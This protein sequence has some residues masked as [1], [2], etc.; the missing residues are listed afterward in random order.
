MK[1][2]DM[3]SDTLMKL[4]D[5]IEGQSLKSND[6]ASVDF[7][8]MKES[9]CMAQFFAIFLLNDR[10]FEMLNKTPI[11]DDEYIN[12]LV[13]VLKTSVEEN[14]DIIAMAY[15]ADD[16]LKN[17]EEGKM[18]A[19][20][21]IEDGRSIDN[22]L[23]KIRGYYDLGV[24]LIG[25][26]WNFENCIGFPNSKD[27]EI[28]NKGLKDFG[29]EVVEYMNDIGMIVDVSH[30]S[31]GGFWDVVDVS[32]KPFV[33]SHSNSRLLS[34][35]QR[36]LK[37]D[38]IRA[39]GEKGGVAGL[40]FGPE[41]LNE[42]ISLKDSTIELMI[43]HLNHIKNIGGEDVIALG[44]DFDGIGG[45]LEIDS[46]HKMPL[47]FEALRKANWTEEQ[48]EKLAYKNVLRVM[49]ETMK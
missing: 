6:I 38:M 33:A 18:S 22:D 16:M 30:L 26:T 29:K 48:I 35:H 40:N 4:S 41:F 3:H 1:Y 43:K 15:K 42:D 24:R 12:K 46:S 44:S 32:K 47:L 31:D 39:L 17:Y 14:K 11:S 9:N 21:T 25:L 45:N 7:L 19:I 8:R 10:I 5:P 23:N 27:E 13:K 37:D 20:L 28:M 36:N 2:I 49:K 34:P